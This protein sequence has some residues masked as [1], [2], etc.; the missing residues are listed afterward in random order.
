MA[1]TAELKIQTLLRMGISDIVSVEIQHDRN[2]CVVTLCEEDARKV[3]RL[4]TVA[5]LRD[6]TVK[7]RLDNYQGNN[8]WQTD[9]SITPAELETLERAA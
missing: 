6:I 2:L 5:N 7:E 1:T 9:A 3:G 8:F 4:L